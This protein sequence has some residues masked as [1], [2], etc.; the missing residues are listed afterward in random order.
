[1]LHLGAHKTAS[2]HYEMMVKSSIA[3]GSVHVVDRCVIRSQLTD[4]LVLATK[5][6]Q[7]KQTFDPIEIRQN[8]VATLETRDQNPRIFMSDENI[9]GRP[10]ALF[11]DGVMYPFAQPRLGMLMSMLGEDGMHLQLALREPSRFIGSA[12]CEAIRNRTTVDFETYLGHTPLSAMRWLPVVEAIK[13][14]APSVDLTLWTYEDYPSLQGDLLAQVGGVANHE[15]LPLEKRHEVVRLGMSATALTKIHQ[16]TVQNGGPL[17]RDT[18][19]HVIASDPKSEHNPGPDFFTRREREV[20]LRNYRRDLIAFE[21][22]PGVHLMRSQVARRMIQKS[23][24]V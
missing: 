7:T 23:L 16:K 22:M 1:M 12:Y 4:H 14:A 9:I 13:Q 21:Q 6:H 11:R 19:E 24:A 3:P 10:G 18:I 15:L 8:L 20:L 17:D 2:S 5:A